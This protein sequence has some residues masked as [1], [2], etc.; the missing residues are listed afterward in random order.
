MPGVATPS[1]AFAAPASGADALKLF[2]AEALPPIVVKAWRAV[3]PADVPLVPVG[4]IDAESFASYLAA[5]A[6][7]F[8]VGSTLHKPGRSAAEVGEI[9]GVLRR[10]FEA[11]GACA[12]NPPEVFSTSGYSRRR[13][14]KRFR[15]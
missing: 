7:A 15:K 13:C 14:A 2:P 3:L 8:G 4:G 11:V 9:A 12:L 5:G 1:E 6:N 10:A